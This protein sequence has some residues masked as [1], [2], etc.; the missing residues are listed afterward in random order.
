MTHTPEEILKKYWG[1]DS[2]RPLQ[3]DIIDYVL[4]GHDALGLLPT[5]GGKSVIFQV[6]G[7][8]LGGITIVVTPLVSLMKDQV[9]NL[10][11][12]G[13]RAVSLHSG[14]SRRETTL[15][16][17]RLVNGKANF[18]YVSPE[19]L[20]N[21][22]FITELRHLP[23]SLIAVDEAHCISQWG[24]DF[25]PDYLH[26]AKLR[27]VFPDVK[28]LALTATATPEVAQDI[29][30]QLQ[31][32]THKVFSMSFQRSNISYIVRQ[33]P[34]KITELQHIISRT[35]GATIVYVRSRK[36]TKEIAEFLSMAGIPATFYHAG[37]DFTVKEQRQ[38][39]W[40][41]DEV[42]VMV[43]TNAFGMGIDKP[44]VRVVIHYDLPP[45]LEE[46]YQE[47]G[48]AGRDGQPSFAV[49]LTDQPDKGV[50][51]RRITEAFPE[52]P[53]I[54]KIY[55]M[56][57]NFIQ[58]ALYEGYDTIHEFDIV[59]FCEVFGFQE[60]QVKAAL[61]ILGQAGYLDFIEESQNS[62]RVMILCDR[63][64][65]YDISLPSPLSERVLTML[66]RMY[67]GLFSDYINIS[68]ARLATECQAS[69]HDIYEALLALSRMKVLSYVPRKRIP[70]IYVRTSREEPRHISIPNSIYEDRRQ[71][72]KHRVESMLK[73]AFETKECRVAG[74]LR[75]FGETDAHP[76]GS[77]DI[78][79]SRRQ[80]HH[81]SPHIDTKDI[82]NHVM[83]LL[84]STPDGADIP[85]LQKYFGMQYDHAM[86]VIRFLLHENIITLCDDKYH[87]RR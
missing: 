58:V 11:Q 82:T 26:I 42:R 10:R 46:Y 65:L 69:E 27:K 34:S 47:A 25:R 61:R 39:A 77:C 64:E 52:R 80:P 32:D 60:R 44:D 62:S 7:L 51:R 22:R 78:C 6:T 17:E 56:V 87:I 41:N 43:A 81:S 85:T 2:F 24:Y 68:E 3:R 23:I 15:A 75:Y 18:L 83:T 67:P 31:F 36:R 33:T 8:M 70:Y 84:Q 20:R 5:G 66:L 21:Q 45:S 59:R 63:R 71:V 86:S 30:R 29:C 35:Q 73:Y 14:L 54:A 72:M 1:Y 50:A 38:N 28:I 12:R 55:E 76:C 49:L 53:I 16:W 40:R 37:L 74:M 13:I 19:R 48:R 4:A 57:C 9:D 79:R